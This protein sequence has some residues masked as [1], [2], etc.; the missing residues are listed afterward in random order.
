MWHN[1]GKDQIKWF[2]F[3]CIYGNGKISLNLIDGVIFF[4][5]NHKISASFKCYKCSEYH[6]SSFE[7]KTKW[8]PIFKF[9][10]LWLQQSYRNRH[11]GYKTELRELTQTHTHKIEKSITK[12]LNGKLNCLDFVTRFYWRTL[13]GFR[14]H[15]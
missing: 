9:I 8:T 5:S 4:G 2:T 15:F 11:R 6:V 10:L 3:R 13:Y 1:D 7:F 12:Q 14:Q